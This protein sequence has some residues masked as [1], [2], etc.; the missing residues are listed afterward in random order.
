MI[1]KNDIDTRLKAATRGTKKGS[2]HKTRDAPSLL[3]KLD[4]AK[5]RKAAKHCDSLFNV[6]E[7]KLTS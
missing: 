6:L 4:A 2:Y 7:T 3:K 5:V 1:G